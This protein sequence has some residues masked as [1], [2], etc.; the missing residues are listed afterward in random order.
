[1]I[2]TKTTNKQAIW[3]AILT[4]VSTVC[5]ANATVTKVSA[6]YFDQFKSIKTSS[7][8]DPANPP[9]YLRIRIADLDGKPMTLF[10][11]KHSVRQED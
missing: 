10:L 8:V 1:M 2:N 7:R 3:I 4:M 6:A 9:K 5:F 11:V